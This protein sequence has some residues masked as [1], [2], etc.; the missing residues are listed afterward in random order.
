MSKSI[1]IIIA[2]PNTTIEYEWTRRIR[3]KQESLEHF[4]EAIVGIL[5]SLITQT[6]L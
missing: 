6:H 2:K 4:V 1:A 5:E 3:L